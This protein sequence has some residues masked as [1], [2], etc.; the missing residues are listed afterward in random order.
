MRRCGGTLMLARASAR[1]VSRL[2]SALTLLAVVVTACAPIVQP[3]TAGR[4]TAGLVQPPAAPGVTLAPNLHAIDGPI[5]VPFEENHG[6][7]GPDVAYLL[8]AGDLQAG[9][10]ADG[11]TYRLLAA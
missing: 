11:I 9:F 10:G 6:Q 4:M 7:A 5:P 1:P 2:V 3:P 8:R